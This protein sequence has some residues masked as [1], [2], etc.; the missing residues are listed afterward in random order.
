MIPY[1]IYFWKKAE[2]DFLKLQKDIQ[3]RI[4]Q[5]L[6]IAQVD[7]FMYF[8]RLKGRTDYKLRIGDYRIIADIK[9]TERV[10]ELTKIGHRRN[11][12]K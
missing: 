6:K 1:R 12:Y 10:I 3:E 4:T 9:Q 7:P 2:A 8:I 11:I 5:K